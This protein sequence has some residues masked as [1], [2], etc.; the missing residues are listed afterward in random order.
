MINIAKEKNLMPEQEP[1]IR[2]HNFQEVYEG[3][4]E[5]M[6]IRE[7]MRCLRCRKK[8]CMNQG[9]PVHNHI[10]DFI[11]K[12][13]E[14]E[15]EE[16]YKILSETTCLPA[17][18]G[19]VC[20]QAEQCEG[21]CV[22]GIKGEPVAIGNLERFVADW[23]RK[24]VKETIQ[25]VE[26]NGRKVAVIGAGPAGIA[27]AGD[28]IDKGYDVTVYEKMD[29]AGGVMAYGIPEFRLPKDIVDTE[30]SKLKEKGVKFET[31]TAVGSAVSI[32]D[33]MDNKGFEAVFIGNGAGV[34][35]VMGIPGEDLK[36]VCTASDYLVRINLDKAYDETG[37]NPLPKAKKIAVIGGGN[38]AID[39][40]RS[41]IRTGAEK[42]YLVYRRSEQEMPAYEVEVKEAK[43]EG[44][45]PLFLTNPVAIKGDADGNVTGMECVKMAL[46]EPDES[47]RRSPKPVEGYEFILDVDFVIMAIG[48][49]FD[50]S[51]AG[52]VKNLDTTAKGGVV[53][54]ETT[55]ATSRAGVFAGGDA[56]TGPETV[57]RAMGAG[58]K[59]AA[60]IDA[61]L[62]K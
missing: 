28:L 46:G 49:K 43:D 19:R 54:D 35:S 57:I 55:T 52:N 45:E 38:V 29:V 58:K 14:G 41:A 4:T 51:V 16:A 8:P 59:A 32:D 53:A 42:V 22:R 13:A 3:Y 27:C 17:V 44:I 39:A 23:H 21:S 7:A 11:A 60:S 12:V 36:G 61:Y 25:P 1:E 31:G 33:L 10:P 18:C 34:P 2:N 47:G 6:A 56:V 26:S 40:A 5:D 30:I 15:F 62:K 50:P 24:N 48:T 9:C 20:P 37:K